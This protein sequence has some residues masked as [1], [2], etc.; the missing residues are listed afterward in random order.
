LLVTGCAGLTGPRKR[1]MNPEKIDVPCMP[2][3]RQEYRGRDQLAYPDPSW[4]RGPRTWADV[5]EG[6]Y[7]QLSH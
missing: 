6:Q 5:P 7:G 3:P 4:S 1:A 2:I